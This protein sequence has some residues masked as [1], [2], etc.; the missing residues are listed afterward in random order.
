[1]L[2]VIRSNFGSA[3][4]VGP[5]SS[6][7][8]RTLRHGRRDEG[9]EGDE[10]QNCDE[11][12]HEGEEG[13][14]GDEGDEGQGQR[15]AGQFPQDQVLV[16]DVDGVVLQVGARWLEVGQRPR[17]RDLECN[18]TPW[19]EQERREGLEGDGHEGGEGDEGQEVSDE[20]DEGFLEGLEGDEGQE[21]SLCCHRWSG[22]RSLPIRLCCA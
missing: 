2:M 6:R 3:L 7:S 19:V 8:H 9:H 11:E 5:Q 12:D 22:I 10:G 4:R 15:N 16:R 20:G 21:V 14:D 13:Q 1:M 17:A 18:P